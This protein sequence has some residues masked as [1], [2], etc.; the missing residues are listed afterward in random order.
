MRT[1]CDSYKTTSAGQSSL[2]RRSRRK[3]N[4][5]AWSL[6]LDLTP[7]QRHSLRHDFV[8]IGR[9]AAPFPSDIAQR[10]DPMLNR[11]GQ[12]VS[13]FLRGNAAALVRR[14]ACPSLLAAEASLTAYGLAI[15]TLRNEGLTRALSDSEVERLFT[16]GFALEQ[17]RHNL[18]DLARCVREW[19][20]DVRAKATA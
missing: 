19:A 9:A 17:F 12:D 4:A 16:L 2:F 8:L 1:R 13:A 14:R 11:V 6:F 18:I 3:R 7:I 5:S 20:G 15:N 10:L